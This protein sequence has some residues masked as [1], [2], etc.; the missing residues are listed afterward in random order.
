M[1]ILLMELFFC[2]SFYKDS[3]ESKWSPI[4]CGFTLFKNHTHLFNGMYSKY[5]LWCLLD[6]YQLIFISNRR[7]CT[8]VFVS[9]GVF[10]C[11]SFMLRFKCVPQNRW[12][13]N[14]RNYVCRHKYCPYDIYKFEREIA[15]RFYRIIGGIQNAEVH[16]Y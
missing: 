15:A 7:V 11:S 14:K 8:Y 9:D 6:I 2:K 5:L 4:L 16:I 3:V 1:L 12:V 10:L 13:F